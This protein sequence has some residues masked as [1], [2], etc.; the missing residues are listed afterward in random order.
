MSCTKWTLQQFSSPPARRY[1][2]VYLSFPFLL[3]GFLLCVG[4]CCSAFACFVKL[5][6]VFVMMVELTGGIV[7]VQLVRQD[8]V[9]SD[10]VRLS[11][12]CMV[13]KI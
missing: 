13:Q 9:S 1:F 12:V 7:V 10:I 6:L 3:V 5:L 8:V 4:F 2:S 11:S